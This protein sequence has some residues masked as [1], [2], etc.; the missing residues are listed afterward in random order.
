MTKCRSD[1][2]HGV[3]RLISKRVARDL[4]LDSQITNNEFVI[5]T[6]VRSF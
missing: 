5:E 4:N 3:D 2:I 6:P 1:A